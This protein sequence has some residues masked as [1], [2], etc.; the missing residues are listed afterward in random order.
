MFSIHRHVE[1]FV[2]VADGGE[3]PAEERSTASLQTNQQSTEINHLW[4]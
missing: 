4:L 1:D 3:A 2:V